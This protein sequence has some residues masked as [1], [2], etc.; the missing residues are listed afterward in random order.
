MSAVTGTPAA[1]PVAPAP[2][3][4]TVVFADVEP[5]E[6]FLQ[7]AAALRRRG[8]RV[9]RLTA[10]D[11]SIVR[12]IND[13]LQRPVFRRIHPGVACDADGHVAPD[14]LPVRLLAGARA[15][16]AVDVMAAALASVH[17][18]PPRTADP[19]LEPLLTDKLAMTRY[20]RDHG[21]AAPASWAAEEDHPLSPP[22]VVKPRLGAGGA[23]VVVV[24]DLAQATRIADEA[25]AEPGLLLCQ[26]W[27]PGELLHVAGVARQGEVLQA[28]CYRDVGAPRTAF[29]PPS[30]ILTFDDPETLAETARLMASLRYTGAFCL[31]YVRAADG[32]ALLVDFNARIFGAW[33]ALQTA[34]L[35]LVGAYAFAWE[36]S[37]VPPAGAAPPGV[38]LRVLPADM[39]LAGTDPLGALLVDH[40]RDV[41]AHMGLL[42]TRWALSTSCRLLSATLVQAVRRVVRR[43][44]RTSTTAGALGHPADG[45]TPD[46]AR[47][48]AS[49]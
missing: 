30:E 47:W 22:F 21:L 6:A 49:A 5:W 17:A 20:A 23:G 15:V 14:E 19:E 27:A 34:G 40:L 13:L 37:S 29:G 45:A 10:A 44:T 48:K 11:R 4:P 9:E 1:S 31:D 28:G 8:I 42:G 12:R 33:A 26:E 43:R 24:R 16:E 7:F 25:R 46:V 39:S 2:G 32:R 36:L 3:R 41:S 35:D 38:R 18:L